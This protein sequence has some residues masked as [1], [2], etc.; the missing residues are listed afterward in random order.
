MNKPVKP[1]TVT[2]SQVNRR[3]ALMLKS[4]RS[5]SDL[6]V[7][8]EISNFVD[9]YKTGHLY[10]TVKDAETSLKC[11]MFRSNAE[12]LRF[13]PENGMAVVI[14]GS[15]QVYERDGAYQLYAA[16]I[17][18]DGIGGLYLAYEQLKQKLELAGMFTQKRPLPARPSKICLI[19]AKTGA[20]LQDMLSVLS[21]RYPIAD[22]FLIPA[23]VQG[24]EA[25]QS[26]AGAF[27]LAQDS[28]ADLI[29]FG[30]GGGSIEDLWAFN[31]E[32]VAKAIY[33]SKI[34]TISAVGH[35]T[36]FTIAD[37]VAD[38]RA[39]TPSAAI[40]LAVPDI[41]VIRLALIEFK[42]AAAESLKRRL[43]GMNK[44]LESITREINVKSPLTRIK[45][46][47]EKLILLESRI[48]FC[49]KTIYANK[50]EK[51]IMTTE[52]IN[53]LNPLN[54]LMRGYAVVKKPSGEIIRNSREA[55]A[56]E[57][58]EVKLHSGG[59]T[60]RVEKVNIN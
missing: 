56:G 55:E 37:F 14:R 54:I 19:T 50:L 32:L 41:S 28:G 33:E 43:G 21:R 15:V 42:N 22:V 39:P 52:V 16:E 31:D 51:L 45:A 47:K 48:N 44:S 59:L 4:D 34:P 6:Y 10:F 20:A 18:P 53:A 5:L 60:V 25:P 13:T 26:L 49:M 11:V 24:K 30:R 36:D 27:S 1:L 9:H 3:I 23:L 57:T 12:S 29:I 40:E 38:L 46:E 2:V 7:K 35:E 8:G 17:E 58:L